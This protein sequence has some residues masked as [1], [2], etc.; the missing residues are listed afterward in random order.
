MDTTV[1]FFESLKAVFIQAAPETPQE[2][3]PV[4]FFVIFIL[5][6]SAVRDALTKTIPEPLIFFGLFV[7]V[8]VLGFSDSWENAAHHLLLGIVACVIIWAINF[9]WYWKFGYDALGMGDAKW[10]MLAVTWFGVLPVAVAWGVGSVL[11][12]I[13]IGTMRLFRRKIVRVAFS[14]F[15]FAGLGVGLDF[16]F[17]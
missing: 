8:A 2:C 7:S 12:T 11:A 14:P 15:L 17:F 6:V 4:T 3:W 1:S 10:T 13:L 9:A 5:A 16:L